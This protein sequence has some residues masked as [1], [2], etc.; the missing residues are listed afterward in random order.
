MEAL[1]ICVCT[2]ADE[3]QKN[4]LDITLPILQDYCN[5][6]NYD[7]FHF[8]ENVDNSKQFNNKSYFAR[9]PFILQHIDNY[10]WCFWIDADCLVM[11]F[12]KKL[13]DYI[14]NTKSIILDKSLLVN[15]PSCCSGHGF[16]RNNDTSKKVLNEIIIRSKGDITLADNELLN[17]IFTESYKI[18]KQKFENHVKLC[19]P[20]KDRIG[21][22]DKEIIEFDM[23]MS[24]NCPENI[25]LYPENSLIS[26]DDIYV[27]GRDFLYHRSGV[28]RIIKRKEQTLLNVFATKESDLLYHSHRVI[29]EKISK[30]D[31][32][33]SV[34]DP[35]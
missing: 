17:T 23:F 32:E 18:D 16:W 5:K 34:I 15:Y 28:D 9:Y 8:T 31:W 1:K 27:H 26:F 12:Y 33:Y 13:E 11:N 24:Q 22:F 3:R 4:L 19:G 29:R 20:G 25:D 35:L 21:H 10:D 2:G 7:L 6:H 30:Y 14:D